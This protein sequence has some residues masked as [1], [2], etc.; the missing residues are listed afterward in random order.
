[1]KKGMTIAVAIIVLALVSTAAFATGE[2]SVRKAGGEEVHK[3]FAGIKSVDIG[4]VSG[5]CVVKTHKSG[6]VIVDLY[7]DVEPE[8][9]LEYKMNDRG[10]K[11][12]LEE[13]WRNSRSHSMSG[14]VV[15]T[16]TLPEGMDIEFST[17]SGDLT[18]TGPLGDIEA[19]TASGD[20]SVT[21][22]VGTVDASTASGDIE[23]ENATGDIDVSTASGDV[24]LINVVGKK[25]V[26]TASGD[27]RIEDSKDD[28]D[29]STASGEI[30]AKNVEGDMEMST[31][32][33]EIGISG[34]KG[35]FKL[36]CASGEIT[37]DE[38]TIAG[39][40]IFSTAS[41]SVRV[42]LAAT[43]EHDLTLSTASGDVILEYGGNPVKGYF[44]FE[45]RKRHGRIVSPFD[46][47]NEEEFEQNGDTY[48]RKSFAVGGKTPS[49]FLSTA[50]GRVELKK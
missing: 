32:S 6:E 45:A 8:G 4:T 46:F 36:S 29:L 15:W 34:A 19:S 30:T 27:I 31:A 2:R 10:G 39:E 16:L 25:D 1:M 42:L 40:S 14:E 37:A 3:T 50:S 20:I 12:V 28:I 13:D 18:L 22:P 47:D 41:G 21:G 38:I 11:L 26:S 49:V 7:Y 5:D 33:G 9:S 48:V 43:S 17:A 44:E 23:I 35:A 24:T